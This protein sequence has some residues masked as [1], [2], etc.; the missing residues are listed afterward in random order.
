MREKIYNR[1][2]AIEYAEKWAYRRNS[3]YYNYDKIGGDCTNFVSQCI[4]EGANIMNY[5]KYG[6]YYNNANDKSAS[7]TGVEYLYKFLINN[8]GIGPYGK[9]ISKELL[10]KGDVIQLSFDGEKYSHSLFTVNISNTNDILVATHTF[11]TFGRN[12]L[13]YQYKKIRYIQ[14]EKIRI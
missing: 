14:I 1:E 12:I 3:R 8:K 6:W 9:E 5:N 11:D 13:S 2:K 7:W 10:K 4:F